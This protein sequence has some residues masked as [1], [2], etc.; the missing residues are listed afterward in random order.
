MIKIL[1]EENINIEEYIQSA[2]ERVMRQLLQET[3][4]DSN[5]SPRN[6]DSMTLS[7]QK[8]TTEDYKINSFDIGE[9]HTRSKRLCLNLDGLKTDIAPDRT[10]K[11]FH[12]EFADMAKEFSLSWRMQLEKEQH[13][14]KQFV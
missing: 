2:Y 10:P 9:K 3:A 13:K 6:S 4:E 14:R 7:S 5:E 1:E 12:Q 11:G 8:L